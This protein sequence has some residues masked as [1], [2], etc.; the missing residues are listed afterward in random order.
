M[1][2]Y[3]SFPSAHSPKA[4]AGGHQV[5]GTAR[6]PGSQGFILT[7]RPQVNLRREYPGSFIVQA[8]GEVHTVVCWSE[9]A[10]LGVCA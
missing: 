8:A 4:E 2:A 5:K 6:E 1:K 3:G 10:Y 9:G 7:C